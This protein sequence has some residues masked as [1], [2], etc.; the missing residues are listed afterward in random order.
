MITSGSINLIPSYRLGAGRRAA[1][2]RIWLC[3]A[4]LCISALA[5]TYAYLF[6]T[7]DTRTDDLA[8]QLATLDARAAA[9]DHATAA[10]R[11]QSVELRLARRAQLVVTSQPDWGKLLA[12]LA[13]QVGDLAALNQVL[14]EAAVPPAPPGAAPKAAKP[15]ESIGRPT[16]YRL[17]LAGISRSQQDVSSLLLKL[18]NSRLFRTVNM[19]ENRRS[20][21]LGAEARAFRFECEI[22]D[23]APLADASAP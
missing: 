3:I 13:S 17:T 22:S 1:R 5:G 7:W 23:P 9:A 11:K 15:P 19:T 12:T 10:A 8:T 16:Y 6:S 20:T 21:F 14:L 18:N 2:F 4:P